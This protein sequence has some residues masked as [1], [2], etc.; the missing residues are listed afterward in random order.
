MGRGMRQPVK[1]TSHRES[2]QQVRT[3]LC[4]VTD[5]KAG[6][7]VRSHDHAPALPISVY[8]FG[9]SMPVWITFSGTINFQNLCLSLNWCMAMTAPS[10][11]FWMELLASVVTSLPLAG[12]PVWRLLDLTSCLVFPLPAKSLHP[13]SSLARVQDPELYQFDSSL[14]FQVAFPTVEL[15][16]SRDTWTS[17][18]KWIRSLH[19]AAWECPPRWSWYS[20]FTGWHSGNT[21][22]GALIT[23]SLRPTQWV[24]GSLTVRLI[25]WIKF[26]SV[27]FLS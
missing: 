5:I 21:D 1:N 20:C 4:S 3:P 26:R 13:N 7:W 17:F 10:S 27:Y 18:S 9:P 8:L 2:I 19:G 15:V 14:S 23:W 6:L 11:N 16:R 22:I 24:Y 25:S 12:K